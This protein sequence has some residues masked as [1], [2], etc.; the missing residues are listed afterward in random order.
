MKR[1]QA[2]VDVEGDDRCQVEEV[3]SKITTGLVTMEG[4][5]LMNQMTDFNKIM[6]LTD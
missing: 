4:N 5:N 2:G 3:G 1:K 6:T